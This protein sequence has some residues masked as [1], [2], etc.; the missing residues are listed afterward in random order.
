M[1]TLLLNVDWASWVIKFFLDLPIL[2]GSFS[3]KA[4]GDGH[5][6]QK[7]LFVELDF[8]FM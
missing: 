8:D 4:K 5:E 7:L 6:I 2:K 1:N 3:I